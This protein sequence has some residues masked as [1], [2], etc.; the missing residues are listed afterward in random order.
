VT[1]TYDKTVAARGFQAYQE[2]VLALRRAE[3]AFGAGFNAS[4]SIHAIRKTLFR[5]GPPDTFMDMVDPLHVAMAG[6]RT[7]FAEDAISMEQTRNKTR[8]EFHAR[9]RIGLRAWRFL[10]YALPRLPLRRSPIYCWQVISHKFLRWLIGPF[11]VLIFC[12]N[13]LLLDQGPVYVALM[14]GQ[15]FYFGLTL[16]GLTLGLLGR[17]APGLSALVFFNSTNLAY[18]VALFR[19]L[20]GERAVQWKPI[21]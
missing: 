19:Y 14:V 20:R 6:Y 8:E 3:G 16:L 9:L 7:T 10:A 15:L 13:L 11:L 12:L 2:Y 17:P 21:R 4:G 1:Y 5:P 18:L